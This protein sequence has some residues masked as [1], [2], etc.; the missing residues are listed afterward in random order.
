[1]TIDTDAIA[2][3]QAAIY[4]RAL[5]EMASEG[6]FKPSR[7]VRPSAPPALRSVSEVPPDPS[8][9]PTSAS[10]LWEHLH[11]ETNGNGIPHTNLANVAQAITAHPDTAGHLWFDEFYGGYFTDWDGLRREWSDADD[12]RL[13]LGTVSPGVA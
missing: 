9:L 6:V 11:L 4:R 7:P 10:G 5:S 2:A 1:M 3:E 8:A 12:R 13:N